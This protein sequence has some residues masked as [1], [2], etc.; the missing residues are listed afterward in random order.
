VIQGCRRE[1]KTDDG[2]VWLMEGDAMTIVPQLTPVDCIVADIPYGKV[3]R[4]SGGL[5][6]LDKG[7]ADIETFPLAFVVEQSSRLAAT[8]YIWCGTEQV[9]E[10]RAGFVARDMTTRLCGWEKTKVIIYLTH[11]T[12][13]VQ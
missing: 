1:F 4:I 11:Q 9:S 6:T 5:R 12:G 3:N 7:E 8:A 2:S 13:C 10:L